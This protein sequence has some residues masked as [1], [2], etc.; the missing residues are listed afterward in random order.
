MPIHTETG[1]KLTYE[2]YVRIP[3]DGQRHEIIDGRHI[4][5]PAPRSR[6][7]ETPTD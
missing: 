4:V 2:D 7:F 1:L 6:C 3:E 5:N